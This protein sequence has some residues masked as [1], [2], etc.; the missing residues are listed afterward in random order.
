MQYFINSSSKWRLRQ[1][2]IWC[3]NS[4]HH[5]GV[6]CSNSLPL[7]PDTG[8]IFTSTKLP[9]PR[10]LEAEPLITSP[11][12]LTLEPSTLDHHLPFQ[13]FPLNEKDTSFGY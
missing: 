1:G 5:P 3:K 9:Y 2:K 10:A 4:I 11:L 13:N 6:T 8:S 7:Y 12:S